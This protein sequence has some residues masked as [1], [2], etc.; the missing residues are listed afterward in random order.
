MDSEFVPEPVWDASITGIGVNVLP[1]GL[2]R[3]IGTIKKKITHELIKP[4]P[5]GDQDITIDF[6]WSKTA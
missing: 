3:K 2:E 4:Y 5:A 6:A 1:Q